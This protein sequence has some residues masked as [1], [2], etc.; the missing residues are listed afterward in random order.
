ML[1]ARHRG[2]VAM[3]RARAATDGDAAVAVASGLAKRLSRVLSISRST[4]PSH[5]HVP[6]SVQSTTSTVT[7]RR[8][9]TGAMSYGQT[10]KP[11]CQLQWLSRCAGCPAPRRATAAARRGQLD[12]FSRSIQH[13]SGLIPR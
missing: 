4:V 13:A 10:G 11:V 2:S 9:G 1:A 8:L 6:V 12:I 3:C 5:H 7:G